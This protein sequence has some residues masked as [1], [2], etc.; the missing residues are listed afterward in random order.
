V[1]SSDLTIDQPG[2]DNYYWYTRSAVS[3][4]PVNYFWSERV[5]CVEYA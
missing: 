3:F 5:R 4:I 1:C 2:E